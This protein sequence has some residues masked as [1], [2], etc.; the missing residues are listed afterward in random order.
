MTVMAVMIMVVAFMA[1]MIMY[2]ALLAVMIMVVAFMAVM[3]MVVAFMTMLL[4]IMSVI[5]MAVP[6]MVVGTRLTVHM[7]LRLMTFQA[8]LLVIMG[9]AFMAVHMPVHTLLL[10][11]VN[12]DRNMQ[13]CD[14]AFHRIFRFNAYPRYSKGIYLL[15]ECLLLRKQ[16]HQGCRQHISCRPHSAIQI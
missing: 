8:V 7:T 4:V 15:Q 11:P 12:R 14:A 2:V 1:V 6:L 5:F 9:M 3:I 16:F 10:R 13:S